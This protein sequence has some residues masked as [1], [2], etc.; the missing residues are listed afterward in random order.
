M[1]N[2][3]DDLDSDSLQIEPPTADRVARRALVLCCLGVRAFAENEPDRTAAE[4]MR[5]AVLE[6]LGENGLAAEVEPEERA[7][8][9][10]AL[11]APARQRVVDCSWRVEGAAVLAWALG[12]ADLPRHDEPLDP[13]EIFAWLDF[14]PHSRSN[15]VASACL[16]PREE[17]ERG[18]NRAF[19]LHWRLRDFH[20]SRGALDFAKF[21]REA[22]FGPL[23]IGGLALAEGD[24]AVGGVALMKADPQQVHRATSLARERHHAHNWLCGDAELYS[25][26]DTST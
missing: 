20:L 26:V 18:A 15:L 19:S 13:A 5:A 10:A 21:A 12:R 9:E 3:P 4:R 11:G 8:L 23:E 17:I 24:L 6:Q 7:F 14:A 1:S 16:R 22:W 2:G 25:D